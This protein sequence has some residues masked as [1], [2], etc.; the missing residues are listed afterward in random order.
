MIQ[1][2][3]PGKKPSQATFLGTGDI[4]NAPPGQGP[5]SGSFTGKTLLGT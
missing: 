3:K 1:G 5:S 2:Q 4:A